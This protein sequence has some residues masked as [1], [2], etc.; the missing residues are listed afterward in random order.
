ME[1]GKIT[2]Q[3][4][5]LPAICAGIAVVIV[6]SLALRAAMRIRKKRLVRAKAEKEA[7]RLVGLMRKCPRLTR[8]EDRKLALRFSKELDDVISAH[9][10]ALHE[11]GTSRQEIDRILYLVREDVVANPRYDQPN[12]LRR[13]LNVKEPGTPGIEV[14]APPP[15]SPTSVT[16]EEEAVIF[17]AAFEAG[18][19]ADAT[20]GGDA[21]DEIAVEILEPEIAPAPVPN[22]PLK[23]LQTLGDDELDAFVI[24]RFDAMTVKD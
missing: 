19:F 5:R 21:T 23:A 6:L 13:T 4:T 17:I 15:E 10:F 7:R 20:D 2:D 18:E 14:N 22:D 12:A 11:V 16:E 1:I 24:E 9:G 8:S 3:L